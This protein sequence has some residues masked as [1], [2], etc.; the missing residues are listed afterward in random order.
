MILVRDNPNMY[1]YDGFHFLVHSPYITPVHHGSFHF[2]CHYLH[3]VPVY[4]GSFHFLFQY[5]DNPFIIPL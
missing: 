3:I 4:D 1:Y 5:P 2:L